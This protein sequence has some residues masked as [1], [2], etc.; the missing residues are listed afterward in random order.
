[1]KKSQHKIKKRSTIKEGIK[2]SQFLFEITHKKKKNTP[3]GVSLSRR[4]ATTA[5]PPYYTGTLVLPFP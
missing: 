5:L 3:R 1:M 2:T 4:F